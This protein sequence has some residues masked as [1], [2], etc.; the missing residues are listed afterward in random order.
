MELAEA[1]LSRDNEI[2][3]KDAVLMDAVQVAGNGTARHGCRSTA[4][5]PSLPPSPFS[6]TTATTTATTGQLTANLEAKLEKSCRANDEQAAELKSV[7]GALELSE[8]RVAE[9]DAVVQEADRQLTASATEITELKGQ[10]LAAEKIAGGMRAEVSAVTRA[11]GGEGGVCGAARTPA[12]RHQPSTR[13]LA[14][15]CKRSKRGSRTWR[16]GLVRSKLT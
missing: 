3:E 2:R 15:S 14:H 11:G 13:P 12:T 5:T 8:S 10:L 6:P 4:S 1:I 16:S 7:R 9:F